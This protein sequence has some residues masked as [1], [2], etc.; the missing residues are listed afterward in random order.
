DADIPLEVRGKAAEPAYGPAPAHADFDY[1]AGLI[2][3][4]RTVRFEVIQ[5]SQGWRYEWL[6]GDGTRAEGT[7]V[8]HAFPDTQG[9]LLDGSGRFRVLL[10]A[11]KHEQDDV[12]SSRSVVVGRTLA[13]A[14]MQQ[15]QSL[16]GLHATP[17]ANGQGSSWDGWLRV[18]ADGGY[19]ITLLTSRRAKLQID[20]L[21]AAGN[22]EARMQVCGFYGDAVQA[23]QL[24]AALQ[25]GLHRI[26]IEIGTGM[27]NSTAGP[28]GQPVL[29]W[30]GP[31]TPLAP[32]PA[33][34]LVS[35]GGEQTH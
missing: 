26:H 24:T 5:P 3:P 6:F 8:R 19:T 33:D 9:T 4:R 28:D 12:W 20:D 17:L 10:R 31:A 25:A 34:A 14:A 23:T 18:P 2:R 35:V 30:D 1:D 11:S 15:A 16:T 13:P 27:E 22:P 21:P 29:Y 7:V 32:I